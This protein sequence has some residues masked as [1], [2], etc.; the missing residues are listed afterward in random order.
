ML[1]DTGR[2]QDEASGTLPKLRR[3]CEFS[4]AWRTN[5]AMKEIAML[6][7]D[8]ASWQSRFVV[9]LAHVRKM[10]QAAEEDD[11]IASDGVSFVP[12]L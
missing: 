4:A 11:C 7:L 12:M 3:K 1:R 5:T 10:R 9:R 2:I 6:G 8:N